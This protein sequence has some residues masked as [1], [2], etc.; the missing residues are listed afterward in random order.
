M[1]VCSP[2]SAPGSPN[3]LTVFRLIRSAQASPTGDFMMIRSAMRNP[4]PTITVTTIGARVLLTKRFQS[5]GSPSGGNGVWIMFVPLRGAAW[6]VSLGPEPTE[7][8]GGQEPVDEAV[9][10]DLDRGHQRPVV[11][12]RHLP[13]RQRV[14]EERR[15]A[16][17]AEDREVR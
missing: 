14:R 9:H 6:F 12:D 11:P 15:H 8:P 1:A 5:N 13:Q 16:H 17:E 10:R 3:L 4:T 7:H 2:L